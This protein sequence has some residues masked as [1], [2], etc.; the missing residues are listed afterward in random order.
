[1]CQYNAI[2]CLGKRPLVTPELCHG[3]GGCTLACPS[4]AITE[5]SREVGVVERGR[6][7]KITFLQGRLGIGNAM[8]PPVIRAVKDASRA[9]VLTIIDAP[10]G[11]SCPVVE[12]AKN[13]DYAILVTEPTPFG[14]H[15]LKMAVELMAKLGIPTGIVINRDGIGDDR[16]ERYCSEAGV[17]VLMKIPYD[18]AIAVAYSRGA[19]LNTALPD[20]DERFAALLGQTIAEVST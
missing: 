5:E 19:P 9:D 3:C 18:P 2:V 15:D 20:C 17:P 6:Q 10:P 7:G 12:A 1:M 8:S 11:T 16:V 4:A 14:L 13:A